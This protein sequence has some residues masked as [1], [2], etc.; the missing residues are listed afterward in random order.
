MGAAGRHKAQTYRPEVIVGALE[1][2]Y[3]DTLEGFKARRSTQKV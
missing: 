2:A 1:T 3:L